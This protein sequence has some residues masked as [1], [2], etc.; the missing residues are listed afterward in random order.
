MIANYHTHTWRCNHASGTE[1]DYI[2][3]A[4]RAGI[5]ILGFSDHTPNPF[6][7]NIND[8]IRMLP[9]QTEAYFRTI[10]ALKEEYRDRIRILAGVE[11]EYIPDG[12]FELQRYLREFG[13]EYMIMG[14][15]YLEGIYVRHLW[16]DEMELQ[17]HIDQMI[18][19][20]STGCFLYVAHP[21]LVRWSGDRDFYVE[22]MTRLCRSAKEHDVPLEF[23]LLGFRDGREYPNARF[24]PIAAEVGNRVI[25]GL[26]AHCPEDMECELIEAAARKT[27]KSFGI[28]D[29]AE[30]IL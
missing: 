10:A 15:H 6:S 24:W 7:W 2:E 22:Q 25:L 4:I 8:G 26:D 11:V 17:L 20:L 5:K 3:G 13:C 19:G 16:D 29:I 21:D 14:Q 9:E 30:E 1:R 12:F 27:L 18:E 23:N 28:T